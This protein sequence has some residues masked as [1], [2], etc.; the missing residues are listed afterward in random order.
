MT[1]L[2]MP[3]CGGE[4][5][6]GPA[7]ASAPK[8]DGAPAAPGRHRQHRFPAHPH[9][10]KVLYSEDERDTILRAAQIAGLRPSSY[11]AAAAL[12]MAEQVVG[13]Q[14]STAG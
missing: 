6:A 14:P 3:G 13:D 9:A 8:G 10:L 2:S 12:A 4:E 7:P 1:S 5:L 11:L